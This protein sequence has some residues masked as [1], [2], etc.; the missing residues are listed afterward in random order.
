LACIA[1]GRIAKDFVV[2]QVSVLK[3][4]ILSVPHQL[5]R[6]TNFP[7]VVKQ[8]GLVYYRIFRRSVSQIRGIYSTVLTPAWKQLLQNLG[9]NKPLK[10]FYLLLVPFTVFVY[11]RFYYVKHNKRDEISFQG[12]I[13]VITG[14]GSGIGE[15]LS[16][17][18]VKRGATVVLVGR[19]LHRLHWVAQNGFN[20]LEVEHQF[21]AH[22]HG[23]I[24][25][26][27]TKAEY[28]APV[29]LNEPREKSSSDC[30]PYMY[31]IVTIPYTKALYSQIQ[32]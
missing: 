10:V 15:R 32:K 21:K 9:Q 18:L 6:F 30:R 25:E 3:Q 28:E 13:V 7:W 8:E 11:T 19:S 29:S 31:Q 12:K 20:R 17:E 23:M 4:G 22:H 16:L 2:D 14:A 24:E 26:P 1:S 5:N 27:K